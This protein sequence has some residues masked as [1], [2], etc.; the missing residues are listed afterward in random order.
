MRQESLQV[1]NKRKADEE[2]QGKKPTAKTSSERMKIGN[3]GGKKRL[4]IEPSKMTDEDYKR[5]STDNYEQE[6]PRRSVS[7]KSESDRNSGD[8]S[9]YKTVI[10]PSLEVPSIKENTR[11]LVILT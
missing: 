5:R 3:D 4:D 8:Y 2:R 10:S 6:I 7:R 11:D 9:R 1:E